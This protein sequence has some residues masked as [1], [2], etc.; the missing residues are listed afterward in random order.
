MWLRI[1][2]AFFLY[3]D[4][5]KNTFIIIIIYHINQTYLINLEQYSNYY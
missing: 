1:V 5:A 4:I 2:C 3:S